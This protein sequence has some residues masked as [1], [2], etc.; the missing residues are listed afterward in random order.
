MASAV[1]L[2]RLN[3]AVI[4][5]FAP[6]LN[7]GNYV[8]RAHAFIAAL[9]PT[10]LS[11]YGALDNASGQLDARFDHHPVGLQSS[12]QAYGMY[13]HKYEPFRFDPSVNGGKPYSARDF[14]TR[15]EFHDLDIYQEVHRPLGYEDHCFV[16]VP[17]EPGTTLFFGLFREGL[18]RAADKELL[19]LGRPHLANA[20]RLAM[21]QSLPLDPELAPSSFTAFGFSPRESEVLY[22]VVN[23]KSNAEIAYDF[24]LRV[25]TVSAYIRAIYI[26]MGVSNRVAAV[27]RALALVRSLASG[28]EVTAFQVKTARIPGGS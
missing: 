1:S 5:L 14:F 24:R 21:A 25:D 17:T 19:E 13:M 12:L 20:R 6:G 7:M 16:H 10:D 26:K 15:A 28:S 3:F 18:F 22:E 2:A 23:G 27:V 11:G 8:A 9:L 4:E